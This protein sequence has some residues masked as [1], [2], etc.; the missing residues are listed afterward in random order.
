MTVAT[1]IVFTPVLLQVFRCEDLWDK[2]H[3]RDAWEKHVPDID[4]SEMLVRYTR[5]ADETNELICE[6]KPPALRLQA[7]KDLA[8][9]VMASLRGE[10][11][12]RVI[13]TRLAPGK[14]IPS[15]A[16]I[17]GDY[18]KF[19]TRFHI[20]LQSDEG[21]VFQCGDEEQ[22]MAVGNLYWFNHA[23]PHSITNY[24]GSDR[25]NLIIDVRMP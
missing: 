13:I 25:I 9:T 8:L 3:I 19:F 23:L 6:W 15:H 12:G 22:H 20:P 5:G 17:I 24:S 21:V 1:G 18:S 14:V 11:L 4:V 10:Q 2:K 16:D 7:A